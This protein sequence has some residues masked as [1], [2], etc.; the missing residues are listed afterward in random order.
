MKLLGEW[1]WYLPS[2]LQWLPHLVTPRTRLSARPTHRHPS[3]RRRTIGPQ[4]D[5]LGVPAR[6]FFLLR[7][8]ESSPQDD[9]QHDRPDDRDDE[10]ESDRD[11]YRHV[12]G[13]PRE[14]PRDA[15]D[16]ELGEAEH[17]EPDDCEDDRT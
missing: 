14:R 2:W 1:N 6:L 15:I 5:D 9:V 16:A 12:V 4:A 11:E 10:H 13:L 8:A 7:R 3:R 17:T